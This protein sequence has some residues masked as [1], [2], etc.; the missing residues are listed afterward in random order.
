MK[1]TFFSADFVTDQNDNLRLLEIN[2]DTGY[3]ST[4]SLD[5]FDYSEFIAILTTT[6]WNQTGYLIS[7]TVKTAMLYQYILFMF[8]FVG[9]FATWF[10]FC[11]LLKIMIQITSSAY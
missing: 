3:G 6:M 1:G 10:L 11:K 9:G 8:S 4:N 7:S 2:T 5:I